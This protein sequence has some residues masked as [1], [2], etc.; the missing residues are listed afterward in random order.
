MV[1]MLK[2]TSSLAQR[3]LETL[4]EGFQERRRLVLQCDPVIFEIEMGRIVPIHFALDWYHRLQVA[5]GSARM[6]D[7]DA[8]A[9][10][11]LHCSCGGWV[12]T[13]IGPRDAVLDPE[14]KVGK[15]VHKVLIPARREIK[16]A[17]YH[18]KDE[19]EKKE[20]YER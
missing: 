1:V 20:W 12:V 5:D 13:L 9:E 19:A 14:H 11:T 3:L 7:R 4:A 2:I 18:I 8:N 16:V 15:V 6:R 17:S 10:L